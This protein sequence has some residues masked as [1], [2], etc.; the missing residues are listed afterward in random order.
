[1]DTRLHLPEPGFVVTPEQRRQLQWLR[2][3]HIRHASHC[4][5]REL[6][7]S[8][9]YKTWQVTELG[10]GG[11][12][13]LLTEVGLVGDEGTIAGILYRDRRQISIGP[14]GGMRLMNAAGK[15][16]GGLSRKNQ[17]HGTAVV[18]AKTMY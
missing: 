14:K 2:E 5:Q 12:I 7:Q 16:T 13:V 15:R 3:N 17:P 11:I 10:V 6:D 1:M 8:H 18:W 9:E 4:T